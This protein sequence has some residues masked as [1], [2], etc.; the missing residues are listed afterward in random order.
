MPIVLQMTIVLICSALLANIYDSSNFEQY[1]SL[2]VFEMVLGYNVNII[3]IYENSFSSLTDLYTPS[4]KLLRF[5]STLG[6]SN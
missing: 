5:S 1:I 3:I 4:K 2:N 6:A